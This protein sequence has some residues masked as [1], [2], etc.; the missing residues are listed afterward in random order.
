LAGR[1]VEARIIR[2]IRAAPNGPIFASRS[3]FAEDHRD[4]QTVHTRTF[5][6]KTSVRSRRRDSTTTAPNKS[7]GAILSASKNANTSAAVLN[8]VLW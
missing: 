1:D 7:H 4:H 8:A 5:R 2:T 6:L 3:A